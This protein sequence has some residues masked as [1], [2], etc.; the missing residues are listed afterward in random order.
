[1][2][3][4]RPVNDGVCNIVYILGKSGRKNFISPLGVVG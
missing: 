1:M 3:V 4:D 2:F